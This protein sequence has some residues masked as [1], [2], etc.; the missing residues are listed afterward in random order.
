MRKPVQRMAFVKEVHSDDEH[1]PQGRHVRQKP[2]RNPVV[3]QFFAEEIDFHAEEYR[4]RNAKP[5]HKYVFNDLIFLKL[6]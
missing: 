5:G 6:T 4:K 1:T 3:A 2:G